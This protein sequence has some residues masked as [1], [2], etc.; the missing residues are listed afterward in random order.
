V[1]V[2]FDATAA[3]SRVWPQSPAYR[4]KIIAFFAYTDFDPET[5]CRLSVFPR[6]GGEVSFDL[7]FAAME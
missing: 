3:R 6:S 4:A 2:R 1:K 5:P 7:D